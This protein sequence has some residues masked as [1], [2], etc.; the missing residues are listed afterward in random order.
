MSAMRAPAPAHARTHVLPV[1]VYWEDTDAGGIVYYANYLRY[2]ERARTEL[3]RALGIEQRALAEETGVLFAVRRVSAEYVAPARLDDTLEVVTS[4]AEA[5]GASAT[6]VQEVR[7]D[8]AL[9]ARLDVTIACVNGRGR[10]TR[11]P[12]ALARAFAAMAKARAAT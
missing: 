7:R 2:A 4:V 6:L 1:R 11:F 10:A 8:A 12:P 5:R 9:L 3:L